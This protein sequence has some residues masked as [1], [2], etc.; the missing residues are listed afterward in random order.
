MSSFPA[1]KHKNSLYN[2]A[3]DVF[4]LGLQFRAV[5]KKGSNVRQYKRDLPWGSTAA[6]TLAPDRYTFFVYDQTGHVSQMMKV[7][8]EEA[9]ALCNAVQLLFGAPPTVVES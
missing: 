4:L 3:V 1:E 5:S 8:E 7:L 9:Q 2:Y 6:V